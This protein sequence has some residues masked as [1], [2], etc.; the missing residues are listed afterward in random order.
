MIK[1]VSEKK[2]ALLADS[3]INSISKLVKLK[4]DTIHKKAAKTPGIS[5]AGLSVI[6]AAAK[7][8]IGD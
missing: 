8:K 2:A 6:V 3:R 4:G 7:K 1:G 5:A